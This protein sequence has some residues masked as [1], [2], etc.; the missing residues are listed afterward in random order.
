[1][2]VLRA[3][4]YLL[5]AAWTAVPATPAPAATV[6]LRGLAA[7]A[8]GPAKPLE[9]AYI[10][11]R[12]SNGLALPRPRLQRKARAQVEGFSPLRRHAQSSTS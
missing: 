10:R 7:A 4:L 2:Q 8:G 6:H 12:D 3:F 9:S 11:H 1:M 5:H